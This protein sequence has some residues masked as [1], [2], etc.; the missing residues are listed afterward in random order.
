MIYGV[1]LSIPEKFAT[2]YEDETRKILGHG[3]ARGEVISFTVARCKGD[4]AF[5]MLVR[6]SRAAERVANELKDLP[7][8]V[9]SHRSG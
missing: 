4:V 8:N 2:K 1:L 5:V 9:K 6:S 7:I 3:I